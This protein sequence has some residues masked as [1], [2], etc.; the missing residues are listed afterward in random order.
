MIKIENIKWLGHAS[1]KLTGEK[2]IYIDPWKTKDD[3]KADI[4]LITHEHFDHCSI[5]DIKKLSTSETDIFITPDC[6]SKLRDVKGNV[7]LV[8]PNKEYESHGIKIETVHAYNTNKKFHPKENDWVGYIITI[9]NK[10]IYHAGDTDLIPEMSNLKN[11][12]IALMPV[13]GTYVMTAEEAAKAAELFNPIVAIPMHC[14]DIVGKDED[15]DKFK[16]LCKSN[17]EILECE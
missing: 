12:D 2:I 1:F 10:R 13:S 7:K 6:Q 15:K 11:I 3:E 8:E 5:E 16:E 17:T 9:N 14:G 4:I